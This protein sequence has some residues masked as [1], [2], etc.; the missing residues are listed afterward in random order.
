MKRWMILAITLVLTPSARAGFDVSTF[1]DLGLAANSY[2]NNLGTAGFFNSGGNS[3]NNSYDPTFSTW[4][5]W[6]ISSQTNISNPGGSIPDYNFEY[7]AI[8]GIGGN[9]SQTYAV[10]NTYGDGANPFHPSSS[11][12]NL[13]A[14]ASPVSIQITN[15]AYDYYSMTY[16]DGFAKQF[17]AGDYLLLTIDG[18]SSANGGGTQVGE[19]DFYLANFL[20]TNSSQWYIVD[21]WQTVDLSSLV[22]AQSLVFGLESTDNDPVYGINT[23]SEFA[24]DNLIAGTAAVP[25][26]SSLLLCL[27]GIGIGSGLMIARRPPGH[28]TQP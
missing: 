23:P 17:G 12:V 27:T 10:A 22:G 5:G 1:E 13:A 28:K 4:S 21:T 14:G 11:I 8:P 15:T 3:F 26:P 25:E 16:G 9:G 7:T 2:N 18:Y 24:A 20:A 19:V 6:S